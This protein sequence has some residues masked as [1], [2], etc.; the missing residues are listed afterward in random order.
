MHILFVIPYPLGKAPSQRFRFEQYIELLKERG[1]S[2]EFSPFLDDDT[3]QLL[4]QNGKHVDKIL[5]IFKGF[6]KRIL[7]IFKLYR[8]DFIF[9]HREAAPVGPPVFE[10]IMGR[11]FKKRIIYDFDDAIWL[12]NTSEENR[13]AAKLKWHSKTAA[14]CR[15]SFRISCG[16][17]YLC[18]YAKQFN[19][20]V[21]LN[22]TTIDTEKVH[23]PDGYQV[24]ED[25]EKLAIGWTGS[26]STLI[27]LDLLVPI[28]QELEKK[29]DFTFLVIANNAPQIN[30]K[31]LQFV[32]WD[33]EQE[34][35]DLMN[36]DIGV[37]PLT[38]DAWAKGK[39][40]FKAL[41]YMALGI[42]ALVSPVGVNAEIV[43]DGVNGFVCLTPQDWCKKL[44]MLLLDASL[45][46]ALGKSA[47]EK[48]IKN[49]SVLSNA[50]NFLALFE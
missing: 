25:K 32:P 34:I 8:F 47:R 38:D 26:H 29:Y 10:W 14:I 23:N 5:G 43:E 31:S 33:K 46:K 18:A 36:I 42:P 27:Y 7:M 13:L 30:C 6:F 39:C 48:V 44:E 22:P 41:Q 40:G 12:P 2:M 17:H 49:Y 1:H 20:N 3:W 15:W 37:M 21:V 28:I 4:Y 45:R 19:P 9:I 35:Q 11:I 16:N 50:D 24:R